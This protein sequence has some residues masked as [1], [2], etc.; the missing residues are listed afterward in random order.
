MIQNYSPYEF[1]ILKSSMDYYKNDVIHKNKLIIFE[2]SRGIAI[3]LSSKN[4]IAKILYL[5]NLCDS[6]GI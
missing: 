5:S 1:D 2:H 6:V 4:L 3:K